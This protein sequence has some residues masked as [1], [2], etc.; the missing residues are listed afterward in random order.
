MLTVAKRALNATTGQ[1][2]A[3]NNQL[4][5]ELSEDRI[6]VKGLTQLDG[7]YIV[8][9]TAPNNVA[10]RKSHLSVKLL[11]RLKLSCLASC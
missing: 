7:Q 5:K 10:Q 8:L 11:S 9:V 4:V 2:Q 1:F 6:V 3:V